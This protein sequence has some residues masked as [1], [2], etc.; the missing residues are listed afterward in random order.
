VINI[1]TIPLLMMKPED[2]MVRAIELSQEG[3]DGNFGGPFGAVVVKNGAIIAEG[4]NHVTSTN[5]P[6][7]HG[8][9]VAI[10]N[11]GR[12][13]NQPWLEGCDLYTSCEPCPMCI[14]AALWAHIQKIVYGATQ[15]DAADIGF[16]DAAFYEELQMKPQGKILTLQQLMREEAVKVMQRWKTKNDKIHY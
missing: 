9:V 16:D 5:D 14:S 2:F 1:D 10:R 15:Q 11:A 12:N 8:E 3:M 6:T 13:L 4:F 7:A